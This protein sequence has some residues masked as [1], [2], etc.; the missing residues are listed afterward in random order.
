MKI[1]VS[2]LVLAL[3]VGM[4]GQDFPNELHLRNQL[5]ALAAAENETSR[6]AALKFF[7]ELPLNRLH[8]IEIAASREG[9]DVQRAFQRRLPHRAWVHVLLRDA[10]IGEARRK[11]AEIVGPGGKN[12]P[13]DFETGIALLLER[14]DRESRRL[15]LRLFLHVRPPDPARLIP[16]LRS[17]DTDIATAAASALGAWGDPAKARE[18]LEAFKGCASET[19]RRLAY[20][21]AEAA[22]PDWTPELMELLKSAPDRMLATA[23][24][25][26][27]MADARAEVALIGLLGVLEKND[28]Y[29]LIRA[30]SLVGGPESI[31]AIRKYHD[32]LPEGDERRTWCFDALVRLRA[33]GIAREI[34][35]EARAGRIGL[36][37]YD[38]RL[39]MLGDR[40]V[41]PDLAAWVQDK[42]RK[43]EC[44]KSA[45]RLLGV[46]GDGRQLEL[47]LEC[48][49]DERLEGSSAQALGALGDPAAAGPL[50]EAFKQSGSGHEISKALMS[51]PAPL[52]DVDAPLLEILD[53]PE[54]HLVLM[55]DAVRIAVRSGS[56]RLREKLLDL[57]T[58]TG[59]R[60]YGR[61]HVAWGILPV[62]QPGDR[63]AL[64]EGQGSS[65]RDL[66]AACTVALAALGDAEAVK[67]FVRLA[68]SHEVGA[69][70]DPEDNVL[71]RFSTPPPGMTEA[72]EAAF[73][74]NPKWL[75]GAEFLAHSGRGEGLGLLKEHAKG[76]FTATARRAGRAL[77]RLGDRFRIADFLGKYDC[78]YWYPEGEA[79][80]AAAIDEETAA[81]LRD[82][83]WSRR[84]SGHAAGRVLARRADKAMEPLFRSVVRREY[85]DNEVSDQGS[86]GVMALALAKLGARDLQPVFLRWLRSNAAGRRAL[87]ARCLA[88]LGDR[89]SIHSI[90]QLLPDVRVREAAIDAIEVLSD[91]EFKGMLPDRAAAARAWY[92]REKVSIPSGR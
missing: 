82:V 31:A 55:N 50:A 75:D 76:G 87:A 90:A 44:R 32:A 68:V 28:R 47:L 80:L 19:A 22:D 25:L 17:P 71:M 77:L 16:F 42:S 29:N 3:L 41:V 13:G 38:D 24:V 36:K 40:S 37:H 65:N 27:I 60:L 18:I 70:T 33:P 8:S 1:G 64:K 69:R 61:Q 74:K 83:A 78:L 51:L 53:D 59:E 52:R 34:L 66:H 56:A 10:R 84:L 12:R 30:L 2:S 62:L 14:E 67:E 5:K 48:L 79:M 54:G 49:K 43:L 91:Q 92:E 11:E 23:R 7:D 26:M 39:E 15:A 21:V 72:V 86:D 58:R 6:E 35:S 57:V 73:H 45:I 46:L 20:T 63:A 85:G 88:I 4:S 89:A 9:E 81:G